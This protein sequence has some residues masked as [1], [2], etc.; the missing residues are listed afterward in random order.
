M[1]ANRKNINIREATEHFPTCLEKAI[2]QYGYIDEWSPECDF[3]A[4]SCLQ[5]CLRDNEEATKQTSDERTSE[6]VSSLV[7]IHKLEYG[8]ENKKPFGSLQSKSLMRFCAGMGGENDA[9]VRYSSTEPGAVFTTASRKPLPPAT[10]T[11]MEEKVCTLGGQKMNFLT[12]Q[13]HFHMVLMYV[14]IFSISHCIL[15]S[16]N[17]VVQNPKLR[18]IQLYRTIH[19]EIVMHVESG[20]S[21]IK[22]PIRSLP[23]RYHVYKCNHIMTVIVGL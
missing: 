3:N 11:D 12:I 16:K 13:Y 21:R 14:R 20:S 10:M 4:S 6:P 15:L 1:W 18:K 17:M 23:M 2:K 5:T 8:T 9:Y 22:S 7:N 19:C